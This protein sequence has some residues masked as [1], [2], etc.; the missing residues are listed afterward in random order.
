MQ[1]LTIYPES[2][3][4]KLSY[5]VVLQGV[6]QQKKYKWGFSS[7]S[8]ASLETVANMVDNKQVSQ[9]NQNTT[10]CLYRF[11]TRTETVLYFPLPSH[12]RL[13]QA[14]RSLSVVAQVIVI[15]QAITRL[16]TDSAT[17][18]YSS[19]QWPYFPAPF[20]FQIV[21]FI[22]KV[23]PAL[24]VS[25]RVIR[26]SFFFRSLPVLDSAFDPQGFSRSLPVSDSDVH[27]QDFSRSLPVSD[28]DIHPQGF[29]APFPVSDSH[30]LPQDFSRSHPVSHRDIRC[31][32]FPL[33]SHFR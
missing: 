14:S 21:P 28:S 4:L 32:Y 31:S 24:I 19:L 26:Y 10:L 1:Y 7:P 23:L 16:P 12:F 15:H 25:H 11:I 9:S 3:L 2:Y 30:V 29:P 17:F 8:T 18:S 33:S 20:P 27:S 13:G 22:H 6:M 5:D